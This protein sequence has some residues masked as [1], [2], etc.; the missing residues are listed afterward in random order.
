ML[1]DFLLE[2]SSLPPS[3][4]CIQYPLS[5]VATLDPWVPVAVKTLIGFVGARGTF[6]TVYTYK[7]L[8]DDTARKV[9]EPVE[10]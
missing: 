6:Q 8:R 1:M 3:L 10:S 4:I 7:T 5:P 2:E 9:Y